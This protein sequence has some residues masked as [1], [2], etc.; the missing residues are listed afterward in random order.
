MICNNKGPDQPAH[1]R[2][3]ISNFYVCFF[4]EES[5]IDLPRAKKINFLSS[6]FSRRDWF[7]TRFV[8]NPEDRF[9]RVVACVACSTALGQIL[10][11]QQ[12][13]MLKQ[14]WWGGCSSDIIT[15]VTLFD[16]ALHRLIHKS[17]VTTAHRDWKR[18][19]LWF[20][21]YRSL[22]WPCTNSAFALLVRGYKWLGAHNFFRLYAPVICDHPQLRGLSRNFTLCLQFPIVTTILWGAA[23]WQNHNSSP[24]QSIFI[25][26]GIVCLGLS[27]PYISS[28]L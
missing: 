9:S 3:I 25:L 17:F 12:I 24:P 13:I 23:S 10:Q 1:P 6:L 4:W 26:R 8:G 15:R 19:G 7:E 2:S 21:G 22:V 18:R 20:S 28:A 27:N 16:G 11:V 5:S 14:I